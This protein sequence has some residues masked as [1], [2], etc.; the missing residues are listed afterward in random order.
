MLSPTPVV[1]A[2]VIVAC[3]PNAVEVSAPA[4]PWAVAVARASP[5]PVVAREI[6]KGVAGALLRGARRRHHGRH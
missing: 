1:A 6:V 3:N 5:A 4:A 2:A